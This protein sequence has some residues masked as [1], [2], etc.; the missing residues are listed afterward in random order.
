M[1]DGLIVVKKT[2]IKRYLMQS[3]DFHLKKREIPGLKHIFE[4]LLR[5]RHGRLTNKLI[6]CKKKRIT[7]GEEK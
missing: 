6:N 5:H 7:E 1:F 2:I 3:Q 4:R